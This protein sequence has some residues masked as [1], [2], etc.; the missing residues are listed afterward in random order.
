MSQESVNNCTWSVGGAL[1]VATIGRQEW[2]SRVTL[3]SLEDKST[4]S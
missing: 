2:K 3:G 1:G 4:H